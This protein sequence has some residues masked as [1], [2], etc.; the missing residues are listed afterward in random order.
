MA[1]NYSRDTAAIPGDSGRAPV[2]PMTHT[3]QLVCLLAHAASLSLAGRSPR[4]CVIAQRVRD[5]L[6]TRGP[7][8]ATQLGCPLQG[9]IVLG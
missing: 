3:P 2:P 4:R 7:D 5:G 1:A 8:E 9:W 6:R